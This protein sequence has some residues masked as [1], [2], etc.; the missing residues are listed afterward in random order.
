MKPSHFIPLLSAF[1][2][3][4]YLAHFIEKKE[5]PLVVCAVVFAGLATAQQRKELDP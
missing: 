2:A 3:G 1:L 5:A 4:M